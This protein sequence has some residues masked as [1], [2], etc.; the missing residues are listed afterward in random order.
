MLGLATRFS[1][2]LGVGRLKEKLMVAGLFGFLREGV[3]F[4]FSTNDPGS[5]EDLPLVCSLSFLSLTSK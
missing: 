1:A 2:S 4:A 5:K 3:R